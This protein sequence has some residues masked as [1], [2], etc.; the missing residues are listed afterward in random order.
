MNE[1]D[2][3]K[4]ER[5]IIF[6][7]PFF[8]KYD[9]TRETVSNELSIILDLLQNKLLVPVFPTNFKQDLS[10]CYSFCDM[11]LSSKITQIF[12]CIGNFKKCSEFF[13]APQNPK[14]ENKIIESFSELISQCGEDVDK[15]NP[16]IKKNFNAFPGLYFNLISQEQYESLL[17]AISYNN[18]IIQFKS[19]YFKKYF[20]RCKSL[21]KY[22]E[23]EYSGKYRIDQMDTQTDGNKEGEK[24]NF[25][26]FHIDDDY[27]FYLIDHFFDITHNI[28]N[29]WKHYIKHKEYNITGE[30]HDLITNP[31]FDFLIP[32]SIKK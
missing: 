31:E 21:E 20:E 29:H 26:H 8:I 2:Y 9:F 22:C 15:I 24:L 28:N 30:V 32:M 23:T 19:D 12:G 6:I 5:K 27:C 7:I 13:L 25:P 1:S 11:N 10:E 17:T 4:L 16:F 18:E 3:S 14:R